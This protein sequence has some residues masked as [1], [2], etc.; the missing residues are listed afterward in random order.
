M[1]LRSISPLE[2]NLPLPASKAV[3]ISVGMRTTQDPGLRGGDV[4]DIYERADGSATV[5]IADVSSKG[6]LGIGN[7]EILREAFRREARNERRP[8]RIITALNRM[9]FNG[10]DFTHDVTFAS[11]V[12]ATVSR[13]TQTLSYASAGHD[14]A[15]IVHGRRHVHLAPTGPILG[16]IPDAVY[17]EADVRFGT[18]DLLVVATDGFTECRSESNRA[19][20]FG[21][22]G[23]L[24]ALRSD[25]NQSHRSACR[26]VVHEAD[27]FTGGTYSDDA[28]LAVIVRCNE[29]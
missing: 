13:S 23:I 22:T 2:L 10:A 4:F 20:Q 27:V 6:I 15:L 8:S 14:T 19:S 7:A 12:I 28:T 24:R 18:T 3:M 16:V 9:P 17:E 29:L 5:L 25:A 1:H 11:A 26:A 21:T